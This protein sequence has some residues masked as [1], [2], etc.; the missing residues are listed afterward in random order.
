MSMLYKKSFNEHL[1]Y[2]SK[3]QQKIQIR[4]EMTISLATDMNSES[5][6]Y[7]LK[8]MCR[9]KNLIKF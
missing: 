2:F 4:K 6:E 7:G 5:G 1:A 8:I 9:N 3:I